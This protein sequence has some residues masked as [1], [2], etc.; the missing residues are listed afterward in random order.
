MSGAEAEP[1]Y[2]R[3]MSAVGV[4]HAYR[5]ID[6][7]GIVT[8]AEQETSSTAKA[9]VRYFLAS[10]VALVIDYL[11]TLFLHRGFGLALSVAAGLSFLV[12]GLIFYFVHEFW[13]FRRSSS[14]LSVRR[15]VANLVVLVISGALRVAVIFALEIWRAPEGIWVT[16]YFLAGVA[17][18]FTANFVLNRFVVFR[19]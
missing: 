17:C 7:G 16:L 12:V 9:G 10:L 14:A 2:R 4:P 11:A 1:L 5:T 13:T 19:D 8:P 15:L 18:S 3:V 6:R